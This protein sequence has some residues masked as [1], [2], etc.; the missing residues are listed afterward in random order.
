ML[1]PL[2]FSLLQVLLHSSMCSGLE[3]CEWG[4]AKPRFKQGW[5][6]SCDWTDWTH[7]HQE[8]VCRTPSCSV[9]KLTLGIQRQTES[10]TQ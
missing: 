8:F 2:A 4:F 10:S 5:Q 3:E 9:G 1:G 7:F 6:H